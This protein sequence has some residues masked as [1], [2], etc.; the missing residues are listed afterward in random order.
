MKFGHP[1]DITYRAITAC[2]IPVDAH[3]VPVLAFSFSAVSGAV[4]KLA[5]AYRQA[6]GSLFEH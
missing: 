5:R 2:P 3:A 1:T 4:D 6:A